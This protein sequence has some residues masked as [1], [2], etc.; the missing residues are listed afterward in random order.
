PQ[1]VARIRSGRW[2]SRARVSARAC[3]ATGG[4]KVP[5]AEVKETFGYFLA[6]GRNDSTPANGSCTQETP[7][8]AASVSSI[9]AES[10]IRTTMIAVASPWSGSTMLKPLACAVATVVAWAFSKAVLSRSL[11]TGRITSFCV[12]FL[13]S[14]I[15]GVE[16]F[17]CQTYVNVRIS[18][19]TSDLLSVELTTHLGRNTRNQ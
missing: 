13:C 8:F 6:T 15:F 1:L 19:K 5:F 2:R 4:A 14:H 7:G 16:V 9:M 17:G 12:I 11:W 18:P 10:S 3:S